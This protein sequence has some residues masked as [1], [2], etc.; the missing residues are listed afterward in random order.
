MIL[1]DK[2]LQ[3]RNVGCAGVPSRTCSWESENEEHHRHDGGGS[4][5]SDAPEALP[6]GDRLRTSTGRTGRGRCGTAR[7]RCHETATGERNP[8]RDIGPEMEADVDGLCRSGDERKPD[9]CDR[10]CIR[11]AECEIRQPRRPNP[12][13]RMR[14]RLGTEVRGGQKRTLIRGG[15][16]SDPDKTGSRRTAARPVTGSRRLRAKASGPSRCRPSRIPCRRRDAEPAV[17]AASNR[18]AADTPPLRGCSARLPALCARTADPAAMRLGIG[19]HLNPVT[20]E[21]PSSRKK[22]GRRAP[23]VPDACGGGGGIRTH[24]THYTYNGFRDRP[25]Q[26]LRHPSAC[27]SAAA[28]RETRRM[29]RPLQPRRTVGGC[30]VRGRT[31]GSRWRVAGSPNR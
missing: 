20:T 29:V 31:G 18:P 23:T 16:V 27:A 21:P 6:S 15:S 11:D 14:Y 17:W 9:K 10:A 25:V 13:N 19:S 3:F 8:A 1:S 7:E 26:P 28:D 5:A 24:G 4:F 2:G 12:W 30:V 22:A